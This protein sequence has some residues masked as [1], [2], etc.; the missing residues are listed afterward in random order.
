[1]SFSLS[2]ET[3]SQVL[4]NVVESCSLILRLT[5]DFGDDALPFEGGYY[6]ASQGAS[7]MATENFHDVVTRLR[8]L[9]SYVAAFKRPAWSGPQRSSK[10]DLTMIFTPKSSRFN[11]RWIG[12]LTSVGSSPGEL[13]SMRAGNLT[14]PLSNGSV[15]MNNE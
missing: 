8:F 14:L 9:E 3:Q 13:S 6:P 7:T 5:K 2:D 4:N 12:G 10:T 11:Q 1:M 15:A